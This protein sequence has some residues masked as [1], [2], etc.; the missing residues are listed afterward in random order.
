M[1]AAA[2]EIP[3]RYSQSLPIFAPLQKTLIGW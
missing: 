1:Y 2:S 3:L